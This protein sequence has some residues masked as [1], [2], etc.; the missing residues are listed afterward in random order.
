MGADDDVDLA[1][2]QAL[3]GLIGLA[4]ADEARQ[5]PDLDR[6]V[7]EAL[8]EGLG[9]LAGEQRGRRDQR[10]LLARHGGDE[11]G[12]QGDLGLAEPHVA[13][14]QAVH[15]LAAGQV[16]EHVRDRVQ[17]VVGLLVGKAGAEGVP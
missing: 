11:G 10:H 2:L 6:H 12:A 1:A 9:V 4:L 7:A 15:G 3:A 13:A 17:L 14:D 5:L 16:L 8:G